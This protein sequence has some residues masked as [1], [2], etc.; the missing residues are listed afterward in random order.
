[1]EWTPVWSLTERRRKWIPTALCWFGYDFQGGKQF[2]RADSN[3]CASGAT[4]EEALLQG[5]LELVERDAVS[6]GWHNRLRY[7]AQDFMAWGDPALE[8]LQAECTAR[9]GR[10]VWAL[11]VTSDLGIPTFV[12][13]SARQNAGSPAYLMGFGA[14]LDAKL[15]LRRAAS[16]MVQILVCASPFLERW[17]AQI[18]LPEAASVAEKGLWE[19]FATANAETQPH[20]TPAPAIAL[21]SPKHITCHSLPDM[22]ENILFCVE[23]L[24]TAG[25][26]LLA[27]EATHPALELPVIRVF[28]PGLRHF[29]RRLAP[30]RLYEVP[31]SQGWLEH[32]LT[33]LELNPVP[34][35]L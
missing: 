6:I 33:E 24:Q 28:A 29:W 5:I 4:R 18:P 22:R 20:L 3:G 34:L 27:M 10:T 14:H 31:I 23:R 13:V 8:R 19:W 11:D 1:V 15:A 21:R 35:F 26:E 7:P 30:G 2:C 25:V 32:S 17:E 9:Y 16:E 12:V